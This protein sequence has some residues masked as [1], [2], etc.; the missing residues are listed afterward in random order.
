M[1]RRPETTVGVFVVLAIA[2][3]LYIITQIGVFRF[4]KTRYNPYIVYFKDLSG[5]NKKSDVKIAGVKVG[6]IDQIELITAY[7]NNPYNVKAT[8]RI[9]RDYQLN[10]D[11]YAVIGQEGMLGG[12]F[13]EIIPGRSDAGNL[14]PGSALSKP[15]KE[16]VSMDQIISKLKDLSGNVEK[17][18]LAL[19]QVIEKNQENVSTIISEFKDLVT[20]L[21]KD[22]PDIKDKIA[23]ATHTFENSINGINEV[24][25]KINSGQGFIGKLLNEEDTY[26]NLKSSIKSL[27]S[28]FDKA[29]RLSTIVDTHVESM[30]GLAEKFDFRDSKGFLNL[31]IHPCEDY[32]F[33][34]GATSSQKGYQNRTVSNSRY[35]DQN[36]KE[37][38]PSQVNADQHKAAILVAKTETIT[39]TRDQWRVNLQVGKMFSNVAFRLGFFEGTAGIAMDVEIPFET[40]LIRWISTLEAYDFRGRNRYFPDSRP[41][42]K[43]LNKLYLGRN[44]YAVFGV[45]DFISRYN[46]NTFFGAGIRF[47]DDDLKYI[48]TACSARV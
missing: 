22:V 21:K 12:K 7:E 2:V 9:M 43:W 5:L 27:K 29:D 40:D 47:A 28:Y 16:Y 46:K 18:T 23:N 33:L 44:V 11:T 36:G 26:N 34:A 35:F 14:S 42:L 32:F 30:Y 3:F 45:N 24:T 17:V 25:Q 1:Q 19:N 15:C 39:E 31:R 37:I 20:G 48:L 38:L 41:H 13:L 4:D 10:Q 8:I 6:W